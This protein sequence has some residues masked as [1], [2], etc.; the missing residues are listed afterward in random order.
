MESEAQKSW[1]QEE[2]SSEKWHSTAL[3]VPEHAHSS[4]HC[5]VRTAKTKYGKWKV[6]PICVT[7]S[8]FMPTTLSV[9][10]MYSVH[11]N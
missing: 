5:Q 3:V 2:G 9:R 8:Y 4:Q 6:H 11:V 7:S 1:I 10:T